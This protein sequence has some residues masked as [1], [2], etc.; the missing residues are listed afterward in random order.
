MSKENHPKARQFSEWNMIAC[1]EG[2]A[3]Q[4][5]SCMWI[6]HTTSG[7]VSS[8]QM[9]LKWRFAETQ[10]QHISKSAS[11]PS[12]TVGRADDWSWFRSHRTWAPCSLSQPWT[13]FY[14][15]VSQSQIW[16]SKLGENW[17][18]QHNDPKHGDKTT[19]EWLKRKNRSS[20][21]YSIEVL[22]WDLTVFLDCFN[23]FLTA[24]KSFSPLWC[25]TFPRTHYTLSH[26]AVVSTHILLPKDFATML[27]PFSLDSTTHQNSHNSRSITS[28]KTAQHCCSLDIFSFL[29]TPYKP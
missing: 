25:S 9:T 22:W 10:T 11:E 5:Q 13:P 17:V 18:K 27:M 1:L 16:Q 12:S 15:K 29:T 20:D 26:T 23:T 3:T 24:G 28:L 8:R 2:L 6:S 19:A 14:V 4:L 21:H 7:A